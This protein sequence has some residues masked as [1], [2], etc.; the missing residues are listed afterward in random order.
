MSKAWPSY[1]EIMEELK[2]TA[3]SSER[4]KQLW[5]LTHSDSSSI[6]IATH[7]NVSDE[8]L[9]ELFNGCANQPISNQLGYAVASSPNLSLFSVERLVEEYWDN[10]SVGF[11]AFNPN[12]TQELLMKLAASPYEDTRQHVAKSTKTLTPILEKLS[13]D[14]WWMI[15]G[16]VAQ[17]PNTTATLLDNLARDKSAFIRAYVARNPSTPIELLSRLANDFHHEPR[18]AAAAN[19]KLPLVDCSSL[20]KDDNAKVRK[21]AKI[22][23]LSYPEDLY[24]EQGQSILVAEVPV[25]SLPKTWAIKLLEEEGS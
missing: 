6:R 5:E 20:L 18:Q 22:T 21:T 2:N 24:K 9:V 16:A 3:T 10:P 8:L 19:P 11:L 23:F 12:I 1:A 13:Q 14:S 7:P 25:S 4:L 15:R 17:N